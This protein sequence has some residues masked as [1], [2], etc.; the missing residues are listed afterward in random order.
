MTTDEYTRQ[1]MPGDKERQE[2]GERYDVIVDCMENGRALPDGY[3]SV[4][5][6]ATA[7]YVKNQNQL[8]RNGFLPKAGYKKSIESMRKRFLTEYR[9]FVIQTTRYKEILNNALKF[10]TVITHLIKNIAKMT[11]EEIVDSLL[12]LFGLVFNKVEENVLR[13]EWQKGKENRKKAIKQ[14]MENISKISNEEIVDSFLTLF[15]LAFSKTKENVLREEWEKGKENRK[16]AEQPKTP[17]K[18]K[19]AKAEPELVIPDELK[20]AWEA[21]KEMRAKKNK[22]LTPRAA[23]LIYKRLME[24]SG[25]DLATAEKI[26]NESVLN[27]WTGVFPL[28]KEAEKPEVFSKDASYDIEKF[29][30]E[31]VALKYLEE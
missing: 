3:E 5:E 17:K 7:S 1:Y 16:K 31:L 10:S 20:E 27:G 11:D 25:G 8:L 2:D 12:T 21:Y 9:A 15:G 19:K 6:H 26:L 22:P 30:S 18:A 23:Q 4:L 24:Y 28:K 13:E 14:L 29:E